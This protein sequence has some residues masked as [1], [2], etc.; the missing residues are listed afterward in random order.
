MNIL[1]LISGMFNSAGMERVV[2]N[3]A[4]YFVSH[5][6]SVT[7]ITTDQKNRQSYYDLL[8]G[9]KCID[10][11]INFDDYK[12]YP[13]LKRSFSFY[14][15]NHLFKKRLSKFL[16]ENKFDITISLILKSSD[17][18]YQIKDNSKKIIEHH[19]SRNFYSQIT[20]SY[21]KNPLNKL[22]YKIRDKILIHNLKKY[23]AFVVLTKEDALSWEKE[24]SNV[25]VIPNSIKLPHAC[26]SLNS[27][28]ILSFGRLDYQK[29]FDIL[30][31]IWETVSE[32]YPDWS[33]SIFGNGPLER[34][35]QN[36]IRLNNIKNINIY[37]P[38]SNIEPPI[39]DSSIYV[40][41]SR[42]EGLP[43][44]LLETMSYGLP[45][46]AFA[47]P[48]GP[49]DIIIDGVNGFLI[50]Q[51]DIKSYEERLCELIENHDLRLRL[52][53]KARE[54]MKNYSHI[55]IMNKW[56]ELFKNLKK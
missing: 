26:S 4:N 45:P 7:I 36:E 10:L 1:Y 21:Y 41:P 8:P 16:L 50:N 27:K 47:C 2:A 24:L 13:P 37:P 19:F 14:K 52:G 54:S 39:L 40:L 17:F 3:K 38:T 51:F 18:L 33:L 22:L 55:E 9:I 12:N 34:Q 28:N 6:H 43:M 32:K 25:Y 42:F 29:G 20:N 11:S 15:K 23:D 5:G 31:K 49:K 48:C 30:L 44:A 35:L 46:V 56:L 53:T